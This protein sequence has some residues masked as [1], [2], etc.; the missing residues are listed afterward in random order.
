[1]PAA[2]TSNTSIIKVKNG[3]SF[4]EQDVCAVEEPL[5]IRLQF[6]HGDK[7][8]TKNVAVTMRTPGNDEELA[9]G[10]L[11]TE[12]IIKSL[13]ELKSVSHNNIPCAENKENTITVGLKEHAVPSL[14]NMERNFYTTSSCGV[15]GKASIAAIRTLQHGYEPEAEPLETQMQQNFTK[16]DENQLRVHGGRSFS[17]ETATKEPSPLSMKK[18]VAVPLGL[19]EQNTFSKEIRQD[20]LLQ[21]PLKMRNSQKTFEETGGLHASAIFDLKGNLIMIREDVGRH[22]ALDK[23][24]GAAFKENLLPLNK[25]ILLLSGRISFELIQKAAM[26]GIRI[27]AAVGAPSSLALQLAKEFNITLV[28]FLSSTRFNIYHG[29]ERIKFN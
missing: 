2:A 5:E 28:G 13:E 15:C 1:M 22:N 10:F 9:I 6:S 18:L 25:H 4:Y 26:A 19:K 21:L 29:A 27:V 16:K 17:E 23:I 14:Q 24:I 8:E 11:F 3:H 20:V 12:G 7:R